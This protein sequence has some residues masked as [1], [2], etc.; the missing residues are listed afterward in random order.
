MPDGR[1]FESRYNA[2]FRSNDL[3]LMH[4]AYWD[5]NDILTVNQNE[6]FSIRD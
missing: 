3:I 1:R 2:A 6:K 5:C 4:K